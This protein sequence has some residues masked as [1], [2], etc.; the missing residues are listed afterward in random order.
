[1]TQPEALELIAAQQLPL[2]RIASDDPVERGRQYG[3]QAASLIAQT[4][5]FYADYFQHF[6]GLP[7]SSVRK[8]AARFKDPVVAYDREI[9]DEMIG[10]AEGASLPAEDV[11][12]INARTEILFGIA[13]AAPAAAECTAFY[14][15]PSATDDG[16]VRLGQNWDWYPA[17]GKS[18]ALFEIEQ[19]D[20]PA[21]VMLAEAGLVGKLGFNADGIGVATNFLLSDRD[22]GDVLVP[23][24]VILRGILNA[25]TL[26]EAAVKVT[27]HKRAASANYLIASASGV[28]I[29]LETGPGGIETVFLTHPAGD[30][31]GHANNY[32]CAVNLA[33]EGVKRIPASP[34]RMQ[35]MTD[36]LESKRGSLTTELLI[37]ILRDHDGHPNSI[38]QHED[39]QLAG[40]ERA[41]SIASWVID[42]TERVAV[43]CSGQPC[44]NAYQPLVPGFARESGRENSR[45]SHMATTRRA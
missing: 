38:C 23:Y 21:F 20:R 34:A 12:A 35:R 28:A 4:L 40:R 3:S 15:G 22:R 27:G 14:A 18:T 10:I 7:W 16:H 6:T 9:F 2:I 36:V 43:V 25:H 19:G 37:D 11:L 17:A 13:A 29:D 44:S 1:M 24:H 45:R 5:E 32:T 41:A 42:L 8:L 26:E 31:L 33:D 30:S 39:Q